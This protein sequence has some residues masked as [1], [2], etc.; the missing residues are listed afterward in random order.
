MYAIFAVDN[1][2]YISK[3]RKKLK[4]LKSGLLLHHF[5]FFIYYINISLFNIAR[6]DL[7]DVG[8]PGPLQLVHYYYVEM[9]GRNVFRVC[10]KY[11]SLVHGVVYVLCVILCSVIYYIHL[12]ARQRVYYNIQSET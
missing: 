10:I 2:G 6:R 5:F 11:H 9:K 1:V 12:C 7:K 4:H 3:A 8:H